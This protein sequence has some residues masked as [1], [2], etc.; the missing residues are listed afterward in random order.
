[1]TFQTIVNDLKSEN[2]NPKRLVLL[3]VDEAQ[4][5]YMPEPG[6]DR[7]FAKRLRTQSDIIDLTIDDEHCSPNGTTGYT[8]HPA[9]QP[10]SG[11]CSGL[12]TLPLGEL[13][14]QSC[15]TIDTRVSVAD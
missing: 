8:Q 4:H 13:S 14:Y 12:K 11:H 7:H 9:L 3:A 6:E 15:P 5:P 1:M 2:C 10:S